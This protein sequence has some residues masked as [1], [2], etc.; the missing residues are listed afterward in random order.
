MVGEKLGSFL[1]DGTLGVGAM[2]VVYRATHEK[3]GRLA[4]VKVVIK[5]V[6]AKG[7]AYERFE[8][9]AKILQQFRH[10]NIVQFYAMGR[11]Q[12]TSYIA[13]EFIAGNTLEQVL[14]DRPAL[15]WTEVADL[16]IQVC[17]ALAYAHEHGVVHRDLKPSN[18]ML[19]EKGVLKLTDFGIAKDLDATALTATGRTLGTAA[20]MAPEQIRG[21]SD[22]SHKTDLYQLGCVLYQFLTGRMPFDGTSAVAMMHGHLNG[23][24]P[25]PS[26]KFKDIPLALGSQLPDIPP[27]MDELV[28]RLMAKKAQDRPDNASLIA[29]RLK[30]IREKLGRGEAVPKLWPYQRIFGSASP[31]PVVDAETK[32]TKKKTTVKRR[33]APTMRSEGGYVGNSRQLLE[34]LGLVLALLLI[35][36]FVGYLFWPPS[37]KYLYEHAEPLMASEHRRDWVTARDE[38]LDPLDAKHPDNPYKEKTRV[39]RDKLLLTDTEGRARML[40]SQA[41]TG[42]NKP[43]GLQEERFVQFHTLASAAEKRGDDVAA[44]A[45]WE[46]MASGLRPDDKDDRPWFLLA[47]KR[48]SDRTKEMALR[49]S[50]V[51]ELLTRAK[52]AELEGKSVE[53]NSILAEVVKLYGQYKDIA[54]F[55]G[56][57]PSNAPAAVFPTVPAAAQVDD[58]SVPA[59]DRKPE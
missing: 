23:E 15:P 25:V 35:G 1:I 14:A 12:G 59:G 51:I 13:M 43:S 28:V 7:N 26:H 8:R 27:A 5:E 4:A 24:R 6:A 41:N 30:E 45:A 39:W 3:T 50:Q 36:A 19:N 34:T 53:A 32:A 49:K 55:L 58:S 33:T 18:M 22:I 2:G 56:I 10:K 17:D 48:S 9:E 38:Y 21:D 29:D 11:Y 20:Y 57:A 54:E 52:K 44:V 16:A 37:A 47:K 46:E 42:F 31:M 40:Q